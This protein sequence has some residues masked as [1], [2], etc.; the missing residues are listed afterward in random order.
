MKSHTRMSIVLAILIIQM[1]ACTTNSEEVRNY[2]IPDPLCGLSL[3]VDVY[4]PIPPAGNEL[5]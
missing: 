2:E 4:E 1:V 3:D 5:R